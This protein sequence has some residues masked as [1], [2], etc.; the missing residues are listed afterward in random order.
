M[1]G[2]EAILWIEVLGELVEVKL[3][4]TINVSLRKHKCSFSFWDVPLPTFLQELLLADVA[5]S[6]RVDL[7]KRLL[8]GSEALGYL[9][10]YQGR[11]SRL[12]LRRDSASRT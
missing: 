10:V 9:G 6:I 5:I 8:H 2:V 3:M 11:P 1:H 12:C 4:I 7:Q